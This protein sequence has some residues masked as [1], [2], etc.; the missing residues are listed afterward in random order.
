MTPRWSIAVILS[1]CVAIALAPT[2]CIAAPAKPKTDKR[3]EALLKQD[4]KQDLNKDGIL[5]QPERA[6][7]LRDAKKRQ[8]EA[9]KKA[10][11][12]KKKA[13]AAR[14]AAADKK[15]AD[16]AKRAATVK[17]ANERAAAI[18]NAKYKKYVNVGGTKTI[19]AGGKSW[20]PAP[21]F[22]KGKFG[23]VGKAL[24]KSSNKDPILGTTITEL[25]ALKFTVPK[26][27][28]RVGLMFAENWKKKNGDRIFSIRLEQK[29]VINKLDLIKVL[30]FGKA[31]S[32]KFITEVSDGVLDISVIKSGGKNAGIVNAVSIERIGDLPGQ[33]K[34]TPVRVT[35]ARSK[36]LSAAATQQAAARKAAQEALL[37]K[38]ETGAKVA[39]DDATKLLA[40][41]LVGA[42]QAFRSLE[43]RFVNTQGA[44]DAKEKADE[45]YAQ[46]KTGRVIRRVIKTQE[47]SELLRF[48]KSYVNAKKYDAAYDNLRK[49]VRE[50]PKTDSFA[51]AQKMLEEVRTL[52]AKANE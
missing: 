39:F 11:E 8:A 26:G 5:T 43:R 47:A 3:L 24:A 51:E 34:K 33:K 48:A 20:E 19:K 6:K 41:D 15:K 44:F 35:A 45:L 36:A 22:K 28:Y 29:T 40:N 13:A 16:A 12:I 49:I 30:G 2:L 46:P 23:Y 31:R 27:K 14:K 18:K 25:K 21:K 52:R 9:G 7:Y 32:V 4:P 50:F 1:A 37:K 42:Y 17:A 38:R 10:A